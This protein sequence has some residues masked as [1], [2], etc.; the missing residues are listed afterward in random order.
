[1]TWRM[2]C[3]CVSDLPNSVSSKPRPILC[4]ERPI[5]GEG[6][7]NSTWAAC[8]S[9]SGRLLTETWQRG[10]INKFPVVG[11]QAGR[12]APPETIRKKHQEPREMGLKGTGAGSDTACYTLFSLVTVV[13]GPQS[14]S[15]YCFRLTVMTS[16]AAALTSLQYKG[17]LGLGPLLPAKPKWLL[18][19]GS[20]KL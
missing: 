2:E 11:W 19:L 20:Q 5:T 1:M 3:L 18:V 10:N 12:L 8:C 6:V 13:L 17:C 16:A 4:A 7:A 9:S 15:L 14:P